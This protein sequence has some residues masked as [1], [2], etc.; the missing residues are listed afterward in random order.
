M[1]RS[2]DWLDQ[3]RHDLEL[4]NIALKQGYYDWACFSSQQAAEKAAKAVIIKLG[5]QAWG[6]S[7]YDLLENIGKKYKVNGGL[8]EGALELDKAYIPARYPDAHPNGSPSTRYS[9]NEAKRM[10]KYAEKIISFCE[11]ILS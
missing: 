11:G 9:C 2:K 5:A 8:K 10:I 7:V 4:A 3:A 1:E 6:H